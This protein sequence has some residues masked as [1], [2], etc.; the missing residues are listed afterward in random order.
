M[1]PRRLGMHIYADRQLTPNFELLA[2]IFVC[3]HVSIIL[4]GFRNRVCLYI[5]PSACPYTEKRNH[6]SFVN[7][8]L[9]VVI[10]TSMEM[11]SR[12]LHHGNLKI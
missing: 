10:D 5:C 3:R 8:S 12:V 2:E 6:P 9:I 7:V 1:H 11:F 4:R